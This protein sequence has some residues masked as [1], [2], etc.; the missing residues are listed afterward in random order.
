MGDR[1]LTTRGA[2]PLR[3]E[4]FH[5]P[6]DFGWAHV[7]H[8]CQQNYCPNGGAPKSSLHQTDVGA[9]KFGNQPQPL[10]GNIARFAKLLK[11][12]P[13]G[14]LWAGLRLDVS[15]TRLRQSPSMLICRRLLSHGQWS[16]FE[17]GQC[18]FRH[19]EGRVWIPA[20]EGKKP[21]APH[22]RRLPAHTG[23]QNAIPRSLGADSPPRIAE[24]SALAH[25]GAKQY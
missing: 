9:I 7:E 21:L 1:H 14:F 3:Q 4:I 11:R 12:L 10:L 8:L 19:P 15:A 6:H 2:A 20:G 22:Y 16:E 18:H 24:I 23:V 25:G 17:S 5:A 13:K